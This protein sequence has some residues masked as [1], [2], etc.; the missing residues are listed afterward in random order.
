[1]TKQSQE[2]KSKC[3]NARC[4]VGGSL[5]GTQYFICDKCAK[6]CDSY[7]DQSQG[8]K[9]E[10]DKEFSVNGLTYGLLEKERIIAFIESQIQ[11]AEERGCER[12]MNEEKHKARPLLSVGYHKG[13]MDFGVSASV[14][15]LSYEQ[16]KELREMTVV[17]IGIMESMWR[18]SRSQPQAAKQLTPSTSPATGGAGI[19]T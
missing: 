7:T 16:M 17:G 18:D 5:E 15:E 9:E 14:K 13:E 2:W 3:C 11:Q 10:L 6:A 8:W 1:M 12:R 4:E 19:K